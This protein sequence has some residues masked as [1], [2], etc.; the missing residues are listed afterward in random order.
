VS[1]APETVGANVRRLRRTSGLSL[2]DLGRIAGLAKGTLTQLEAGRGNPTIETLQALSRALGVTL[3]ELVAEVPESTPRVV[4]R[5]G[6]AQAAGWT[7]PATFVHGLHLGGSVVELYRVTLPR[8]S[9]HRSPAQPPGTVE[10][11][12]VLEGTIE[13]GPEDAAV[14]LSPGDFARLDG[15]GPHRYLAL[16]RT[17]TGLLTLAFP[18]RSGGD[19]TVESAPHRVPPAPRPPAPRPVPPQVPARGVRPTARRPRPT[20]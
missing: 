16:D 7:M 10:Q 12:Y 1:S 9:S 2:V 8:G 11:L 19:P 13:A 3:A 18:L 4:R 17:A 15:P 6:A 5:D 14:V 20:R